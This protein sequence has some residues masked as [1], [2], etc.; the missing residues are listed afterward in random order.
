M[1][2]DKKMHASWIVNRFCNFRCPYCMVS[3]EDRGNA[4]LIGNP[5]IEQAIRF[6]NNTGSWTINMTGGEPFMHPK[7]I[8]LCQGLTENHIISMN[9]NLSSPK[10]YEFAEKIDPKKVAHIVCSLQIPMIEKYN[11]KD[12][13]IKKFLLLEKKGF[14]VGSTVVM[15]PPLLAKFE[16]IYNEFKKSGIILTPSSFIGRYQ[17]KIYP[18]SYTKEE[19]NIIRKFTVEK[20]DDNPN[21]TKGKITYQGID[22]SA[23]SAHIIISEKGE[24]SRCHSDR[25]SLGNIYQKNVKLFPCPQKCTAKVCACTWEGYLYSTGKPKI[26]IENFQEKINCIKARIHSLKKI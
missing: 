11:L 13:Y 20:N 19:Y 15:W 17:D 1:I 18:A 25:K 2:R 21:I 10:V 12:D 16:E 22:C 3:D 26:I 4:D 14:R 23:G 8:E 7:F 5:D 9:T 24:V 6:F